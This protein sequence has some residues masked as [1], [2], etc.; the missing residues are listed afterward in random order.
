MGAVTYP[1]QK[2]AEFINANLVPVQL[3]A[4]AKPYAD[5]FIIEWT[6]TVIVLDENGKEHSRSIGFLPPEEFIPS[7]L[8]GMFKVHF[9]L[10][11]YR[12]A[13]DIGDKLVKDYPKSKAVPE[14]IFWQGVVSYKATHDPS[15]LKAAYKRLKAEHPSSEWTIR[16]EP[17][18]LLP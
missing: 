8:L 7:L 4:D 10:R 6:P 11:Q 12:E 9:D 18:D 14:M 5:D 1:D 2:V 3:L 13:I 17:Y 16:A 15:P